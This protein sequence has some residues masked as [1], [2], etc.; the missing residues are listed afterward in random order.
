[1]EIVIN[2]RSFKIA[3]SL[4][5]KYYYGSTLICLWV[6]VKRNFNVVKYSVRQLVRRKNLIQAH[7]TD[8]TERKIC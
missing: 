7:N 4:Y 8:R 5:N 6:F 1:M 2:R 3:N